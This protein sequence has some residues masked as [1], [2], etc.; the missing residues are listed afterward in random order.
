MLA[1]PNPIV[2][3]SAKITAIGGLTRIPC[4]PNLELHPALRGLSPDNWA[5]FIHSIF[6]FVM[7]VCIL[8]YID[9]N[10]NALR[11]EQN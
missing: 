11:E 5:H 1:R 2:P 6:V 10:H 3:L 4:S 7:F 8:S 9:N